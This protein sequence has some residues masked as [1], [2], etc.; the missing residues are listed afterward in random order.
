MDASDTSTTFDLSIVDLPSD[1]LDLV[2]SFLSRL[3]GETE[4][5]PGQ[6]STAS[7]LLLDYARAG[8][9]TR[10]AYDEEFDPEV[11]GAEREAFYR[12][13]GVTEGE[14]E[15]MWS[16][17]K[18]KDKGR[19]KLPAEIVNVAY[20]VEFWGAF[21]HL[22]DDGAEIF[23]ERV[24][25]A[26]HEAANRK[27]PVYRGRESGTTITD[28]WITSLVFTGKR[29]VREIRALHRYYPAELAGWDA[30]FQIEW[31]PPRGSSVGLDLKSPPWHKVRLAYTQLHQE[32]LAALKCEPGG[33]LA[34]VQALS[35]HSVTNGLLRPI[36][37]W[38]FFTT[39]VVTAG[40]TGA[41]ERLDRGDF[42]EQYVT[43]A[44]VGPA[45]NVRPGKSWAW[46]DVSVKPL[47]DAGYPIQVLNAFV[48]RY[49]EL[50]FGVADLPPDTPLFPSGLTTGKNRSTMA[51]TRWASGSIR[52]WL[53]GRPVK[54][55]KAGKSG[56]TGLPALVAR[57]SADPTWGFSAHRFRS[58]AFKALEGHAVRDYLAEQRI[59]VP[60]RFLADILT[61]HKL[62]GDLTAIYNRVTTREG[63]VEVAEVAIHALWL[64]LSTD[65]GAR[66]VPDGE[67]YRQALRERRVLESR[68][69]SV[70]ED[71]QVIARKR[72]PA[73]SDTAR[74][75]ALL[76]EKARLTKELTWL[77]IDVERI[78]SL[79]HRRFVSIPDNAEDPALSISIEDIRAEVL[80]QRTPGP[81]R[82]RSAVRDWLTVLE[83]ALIVGRT[84]QQV[85]K[86]L[87]GG[88]LP[89]DWSQR[90]W[91]PDRVPVDD[92]HGL[93]RRRIILDG[94]LPA[95]LEADT[96]RAHQIDQYVTDWPAKWTKKYW[97][98]EA[99]RPD[100]MLTPTT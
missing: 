62:D 90:P 25:E 73:P 33:E 26:L 1:R 5:P 86:W 22:L 36:R 48:D 42:T 38:A 30:N 61:D 54:P 99:V 100:W 82:V 58:A 95:F 81:R 27:A 63:R 60:Q 28:S 46:D 13:A 31:D 44:G 83:F 6:A 94:L 24:H 4:R 12:R 93:K 78:E 8:T 19:A 23:E 88:S 39:L 87:D 92:S 41:L 16:R 84:P 21:D 98:A 20:P 56:Q 50:L 11:R 37:N 18:R 2:L 3:I 79:D 67:G 7:A 59:E 57:T 32:A 91:E 14:L 72:E 53:V 40:R 15:R 76:H 66:K 74:M 49:V 71:V 55:G 97:Q 10:P 70:D 43:D 35:R 51:I 9:R 89:N 29:I 69:R 45:L 17:A 80:G 34:A 85:G 52:N 75:L 65:R 64:M 77:E 68:E 96:R 47:G